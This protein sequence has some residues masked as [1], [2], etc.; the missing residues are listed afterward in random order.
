M[1]PAGSTPWTITP[2]TE[3]NGLTTLEKMSKGSRNCLK[4][5]LRKVLQVT[6]KFDMRNDSV[7]LGTVLII[8]F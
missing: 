8:K 7:R 1:D 4:E 3:A 5:N 6:N 2:M